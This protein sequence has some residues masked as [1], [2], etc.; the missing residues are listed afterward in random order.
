MRAGCSGVHL[1]R[2]ALDRDAVQ[3]R[4]GTTNARSMKL[5]PRRIADDERVD[6]GWDVIEEHP[7]CQSI[8]A[9]RTVSAI[10]RLP[11]IAVH[12]TR[13]DNSTISHNG[14]ILPVLVVDL[15]E[16]GCAITIALIIEFRPTRSF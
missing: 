4:V 7:R 1:R 8:R 15:G 5:E 6:Y 3:P 13:I 16:I 11:E 12:V 9:E 10:R 14:K 2:K